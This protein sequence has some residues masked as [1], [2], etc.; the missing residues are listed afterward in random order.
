MAGLEKGSD[1]RRP[2][3]VSRG[4]TASTPGF[5]VAFTRTFVLFESN[6]HG[7]LLI[8]FLALNLLK[9][10]QSETCQVYEE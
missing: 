3:S 7:L 4:A 6:V 5:S 10:L 2:K 9:A 8:T 1:L